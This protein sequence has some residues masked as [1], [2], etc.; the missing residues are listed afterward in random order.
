MIHYQIVMMTFFSINQ[1]FLL[2]FKIQILNSF[3]NV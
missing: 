1:Q 2:N 3:L